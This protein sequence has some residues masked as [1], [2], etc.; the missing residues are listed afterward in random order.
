MAR[1]ARVKAEDFGAYYHLCGRV[2]GPI[3]E[4]PLDDKKCRR[5]II[6]FIKFFSSVYCCRVLGFCVMMSHS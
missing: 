6:E 5:K 4:Y 2:A 3:G 1:L